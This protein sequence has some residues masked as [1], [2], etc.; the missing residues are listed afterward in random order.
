MI[1]EEGTDNFANVN[2][3]RD[4]LNALKRADDAIGLARAY[5]AKHPQTLLM[6]TADSNAG[7]MHMLG[8]RPDKDGKLP[9]KV[10]PND[11]NGAAYDGIGGTETAPF[12]AQPDRAGVRLPFVV[13]WGTTL[14]A[15]GGVLVR[16]EGLNAQYVKGTLDNTKI[17]ELIRLTLFG[18]TKP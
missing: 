2:N 13:V 11:P 3:A 1:E 4:T 18:T 5:L 15:A 7:A 6:V 10:K 17:A 14:D 16:A 12:L 9:D 8:L